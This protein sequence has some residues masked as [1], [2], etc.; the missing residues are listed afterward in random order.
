[1]LLLGSSMAVV[2]FLLLWFTPYV[3]LLTMVI[4]LGIVWSNEDQKIKKKNEKK[5]YEQESE[6][7]FERLKFDDPTSPQLFELS[8]LLYGTIKPHEAWLLEQLD[9]LELMYVNDAKGTIDETQN[10]SHGKFKNLFEIAEKYKA[11]CTFLSRECS[12]EIF[13]DIKTVSSKIDS[14]M[15]K[16][17]DQSGLPP[18][19]ND[20]LEDYDLEVWAKALIKRET[21]ARNDRNTIINTVTIQARKELNKSISVACLHDEWIINGRIK[22]KL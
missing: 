14:D 9:D 2:G 8:T 3:G 13:E 1:M 6:R 20:L 22:F 21:D 12:S 7:M 19:L 16:S 17:D 10:V 11:I 5:L 4:G 15:S 18:N